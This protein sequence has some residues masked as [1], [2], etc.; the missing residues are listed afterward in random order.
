MRRF[1]LSFA[2]ALAGAGSAVADAHGNHYIEVPLASAEF[3]EVG[4][5]VELALVAGD[6]ETGPV[7]TYIRFAP[8]NS[9]FMHVHSADY[10]AVV[11]DGA[12][13][14]WEEGQEMSDA[15]RLEVG[16]GWFQ[17][18]GAGHQDANPLQDATSTIFVVF[19]GPID[20]MPVE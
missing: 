17:A 15:T 6:P 19:S 10:H 5:G 13:L 1:F 14:H 16:D 9:G 3:S 8:G 4:P 12:W 11:V 18:G 2:F 7:S 20:T